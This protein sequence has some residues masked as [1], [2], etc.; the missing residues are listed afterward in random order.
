MAQGKKSEESKEEKS[1]SQKEEKPSQQKEETPEETPEEGLGTYK[2]RHR[3]LQ[4]T[5]LDQNAL[6]EQ[7][8]AEKTAQREAHNE[9][10]GDVSR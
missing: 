10:T 9:R 2:P 7:R 5:G 8:Q 4:A 3:P 6:E 1:K